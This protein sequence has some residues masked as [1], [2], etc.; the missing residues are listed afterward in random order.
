MRELLSEREQALR[1]K[2]CHSEWAVTNESRLGCHVL[3]EVTGHLTGLA[4]RKLSEQQERSKFWTD[5]SLQQL[6]NQDRAH[7]L[8]RLREK[9]QVKNSD[10]LLICII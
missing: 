2:V 3:R 5:E 6:N 7:T 10:R 4:E 8:Q 9:S 1:E